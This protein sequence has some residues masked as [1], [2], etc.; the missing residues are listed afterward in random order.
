MERPQDL[1][2]QQWGLVCLAAS[3]MVFDSAGVM[4]IRAALMDA[5]RMARGG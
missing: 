3:E 4:P 2:L 1:S 5:V